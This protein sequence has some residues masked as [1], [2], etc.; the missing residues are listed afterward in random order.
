MHELV[1]A[2]FGNGMAERIALV[3]RSG[4]PIDVPE[5]ASTVVPGGLLSMRAMPLPDRC[6][7]VIVEDVTERRRLERE[8]LEYTGNLEA[9]INAR[10]ARIRELEGERARAEKLAAAGRLAARV[11]HEIIN[12]LAGIKNA[13]ALVKEGV[14]P[15]FEHA[16]YVPRIERE[17]D[18][19]ARIVSQMRELYRPVAEPVVECDVAAL[20]Q[21]VLA[22]L[23]PEA[24][25]AGVTCRL[26]A[27][28]RPL[29]ARLQADGVRQILHNLLRNA[30]DVSPR[31]GAIDLTVTG[32]ERELSFLIADQGPGV[33]AD[34][35]EHMFE[36]FFTTKSDSGGKSGL[37]LGLSIAQGLAAAMRGHL[38]LVSGRAAGAAFRLTI[39]RDAG[40]AQA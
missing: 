37:G 14:R 31:G 21:D 23:E 38:S 27:A 35:A 39:P 3:A 40:R 30:L 18:R 24:C 36:P 19:I 10:I 25:A 15:D 7:G 22:L 8:L 16:H 33:P 5:V 4:A 28:E 26:R 12:P 13:F 1:P 34:V 11:A 29:A 20:A 2:A 32:E 6:V 9:E 17:I